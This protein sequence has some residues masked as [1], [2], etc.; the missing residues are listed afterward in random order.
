MCLK[1]SKK[2]A[3]VL[4][5]IAQTGLNCFCVMAGFR[6]KNGRTFVSTS[7][8]PPCPEFHPYLPTAPPLGYLT[9][10]MSVKLGDPIDGKDFQGP[11]AGTCAPAS[12]TLAHSQ[13][14][15]G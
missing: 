14:V 8:G 15:T 6:G 4:I 9:R 12:E 3:K 11:I 10:A 1:Y 7:L 2:V 13:A 5:D